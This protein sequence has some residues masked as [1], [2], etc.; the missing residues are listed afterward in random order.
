MSFIESIHN[1]ALHSP[2]KTAIVAYSHGIGTEGSTRLSYAEVYRAMTHCYPLPIPMLGNS[3]DGD[4]TLHT[5][6]S[7]GKPKAVTVSRQ[8][9]M[10]NSLNLIHAHGYKEDLQFIIAGPMNHLG[11]WSK[12]FPTLMVGGT[13]HILPDGMKDMEAFFDI[14][15]NHGK[16]YATFLVPSAIRMLIQFAS[17]RLRYCSDCIEFIETGGAPI[18]HSDMLRLCELLPDSRLYNT[19]ASTE[20]GIVAT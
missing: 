16:R 4:F 15:H 8:V 1:I 3:W 17:E 18:A 2:D 9:V 7:T 14:M 10:R 12:L 6:G 20:A 13:L 5:T 11:C 19:Y